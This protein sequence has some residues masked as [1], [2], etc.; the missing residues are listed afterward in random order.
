MFGTIRLIYFSLSVVANKKRPILTMDDQALIE[1]VTLRLITDAQKRERFDQLMV[2]EHYL[3][4][5]HLVG[6][7]LR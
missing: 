3:H 6:E 7:R 5:A 4:N 1:G 2:A